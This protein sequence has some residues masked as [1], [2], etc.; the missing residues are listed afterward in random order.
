MK[1]DT[2]MIASISEAN[3]N[4]SRI[5]HIAD[6]YGRAVILKDKTPKYLLIDL[7]Q[8]AL[9]YDLTDEEKLEIASKRILNSINLPLRSLPND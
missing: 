6:S 5:A 7:E 2:K 4:F 3:K 9:I 8:E 1:I